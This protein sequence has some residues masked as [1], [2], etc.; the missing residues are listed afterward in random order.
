MIRQLNA[1]YGCLE[2]VAGRKRDPAGETNGKSNNL[3]HCLQN[4]IY[5]EYWPCNP[6]GPKIP[7]H[8][9]MVVF[10]ADMVAKPNFF[11]KVRVLRM[12][13]SDD[14]IAFFVRLC[15]CGWRGP[16]FRKSSCLEPTRQPTHPTFP[17]H[18]PAQKTQILEVMVDD[19]VALCLSPQAFSNVNP[20]TDIFNNTNQQVRGA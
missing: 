17:H 7:K 1:Q 8:E 6:N 19:N 16:P 5:K 15:V 18:S 12:L 14:R 9:V 10:D 13:R 11:T 4:V 20:S 3:N 2:Y